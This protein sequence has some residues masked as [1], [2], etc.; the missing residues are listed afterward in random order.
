MQKTSRLS[1]PPLLNKAERAMQFS[2]APEDL[3][4]TAGD[5]QRSPAFSFSVDDSDDDDDGEDAELRSASS[6]ATSES[7]GGRTKASPGEVKELEFLDRSR[8]LYASACVHSYAYGQRLHRELHQVQSEETQD[9]KSSIFSVLD[10]NSAFQQDLKDFFRNAGSDAPA[11]SP[12][13]RAALEE[14]LRAVQDEIA[15]VRHRTMVAKAQQA[16]EAQRKLEEENRKRLEAERAAAEE[17]RRKQALAAQAEAKEA[18]RREAEAQAKAASERQ[19]RANQQASSSGGG[20]ASSTGDFVTA[21]ALAWERQCAEVY[22]GH[23]DKAAPIFAASKIERLKLEKP[24]KKA[25]NQ[26]SC[27]KEQ[28][29]FVSQQAT[30]HLAQQK[31]M[32][33]SCYS[34]C[35]VRL[36]DLIALQ[37]ASLGS[38]KQIAFAYAELVRL[39]AGSQKDFVAVF[40]AALHKQCPL[41]VPRFP[42]GYEATVKAEQKENDVKGYVSIYAALCQVQ[43]TPSPFPAHEYLWAYLA[44]FLNAGMPPSAPAAIALDSFLQI[45]GHRAYQMFRRQ[46]LKVMRHITEEFVRYLKGNAR[47]G[48]G[49]GGGGED[50]DAVTLRIEKYIEKQQYLSAPEGSVIPDRDDSSYIRC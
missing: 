27:S 19:E 2:V 46:Q 12:P 37:G 6:I 14:S 34:Y 39:L 25:V 18:R 47:E 3:W 7:V 17:A 44:R 22:K 20:P 21:S 42:K 13:P 5:A 24:I 15:R 49:E 9:L 30:N 10:Q 41:T 50:V 29:M 38:S 26:V 33:E 48:E 4:D 31:R 36:A 23:T 16:A 40:V 32:A 8:Q 11:K 45:A 43:A 35:L 28:I 1:R